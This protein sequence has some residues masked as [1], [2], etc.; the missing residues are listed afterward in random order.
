MIQWP[1]PNEKLDAEKEVDKA[2]LWREIGGLYNDIMNTGK[3]AMKFLGFYS[4]SLPGMFQ[5]MDS[6]LSQFV[7]NRV[8][9]DK[10]L[11]E[12]LEDDPIT[13]DTNLNEIRE[14][15]DKL[16]LLLYIPL[17]DVNEDR[18]RDPN[19]MNEEMKGMI[20]II[21]R[22]LEENNIES[23]LLDQMQEVMKGQLPSLIE[24]QNEIQVLIN[25]AQDT[26]SSLQTDIDLLRKDK[27][28]TV[29]EEN[30]LHMN[31]REL[32]KLYLKLEYLH[33]KEFDERMA[34]TN[35][36]LFAKKDNRPP[37]CCDMPPKPRGPPN[38]LCDNGGCVEGT[39]DE[40]KAPCETAPGFRCPAIG[41]ANKSAETGA[42][43]DETNAEEEEAQENTD[44]QEM[45]GG[46]KSNKN[47]YKGKEISLFDFL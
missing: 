38:P 14:N 18:L 9:K 43:E 16:R 30:I 4:N 26:I 36:Y 40:V 44:E 37:P 7:T 22:K 13:L 31:I 29:E 47:E 2:I 11:E 27:K 12:E 3:T 45:S 20:K 5:M 33:K 15:R 25:T 42:E 39:V 41:Q 8:D 19:R 6:Y 23:L 1:S 21:H 32:D 46:G 24:L 10:K 28:S 35:P 34:L 17:R